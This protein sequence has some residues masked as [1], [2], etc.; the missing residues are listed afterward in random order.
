[1]AISRFSTSRV[2]AGLPKYQKLWDQSTIYSASSY[3]SIATVTLNSTTS[4]IT[5]SSIPQTY[6]HL[7]LRS[8]A[9]NV[10]TGAPGYDYATAAFN[11]DTT[12]TNYR[13]HSFYGNGT[14]IG[15]GTMQS[16]GY[17]AIVA[18]VT[19]DYYT[20]GIMGGSIV[21]ILDYSSTTKNKTSKMLAVA[22]M[23]SN[24]IYAEIDVLTSAWFS[25]SAITSITITCPTASFTANTQF[26]LYG[27][28]G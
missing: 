17:Q 6:K 10:Y 1:M 7:Q 5:F 28:K 16:T 11:G 12:Y 23:N 14:T 4:T 13:T 24:N 27:I 2:G 26:A 18:D 25:T 21:D 22:E 3:E 9:R 19:R 15:A 8:I 20:S